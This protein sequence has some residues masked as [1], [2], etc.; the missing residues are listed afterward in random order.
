MWLI[1]LLF[2]KIH[3]LS[4]GGVIWEGDREVKGIEGQGP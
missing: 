4:M 3:Y 1:L 2:K